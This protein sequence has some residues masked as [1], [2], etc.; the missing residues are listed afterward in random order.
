MTSPHFDFYVLTRTAGDAAP[1]AA[2]YGA[3]VRLYDQ[4]IRD[5]HDWRHRK[6]VVHAEIMGPEHMPQ[7]LY[8]RE[9]LWNKA[10]ELE[11]RKDAQVARRLIMALPHEL[12]HEQRVLL[13]QDYVAREFVSRGMVADI[14]IHKPD[15][16]KGQDHRNH[17]AHVLLTMR[18][19]GPD[20]FYRTKT[21]EWNS[22]KLQMLWRASWAE[23]QT[24]SLQIAGKNI[25]LHPRTLKPIAEPKYPLPK[26]LQIQAQPELKLGRHVKPHSP[27]WHAHEKRLVHN[28][29]RA[30]ASRRR[31]EMKKLHF[32]E[33]KDDL[34][35][36]IAFLEGFP[37]ADLLQKP[38]KHPDKRSLFHLRGRLKLFMS[39]EEQLFEWDIWVRGFEAAV[40]LR[41]KRE[42]KKWLRKR[43]KQQ[44]K[45][46]EKSRARQLH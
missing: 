29:T 25:A 34:Y 35:R 30:A 15:L 22:T 26:S 7:H 1:A 32:A 45:F 2:A 9:V 42:H 39:L 4:R 36:R 5:F 27:E 44:A 23:H 43:A 12:T 24:R 40:R 38:R 21:R 33:L 13:V 14:A 16:A 10:E 19:V 20:G 18:K 3:G 11:I 8:D 46:K 17:H 28:I 31:L 41:R 37:G 6:D